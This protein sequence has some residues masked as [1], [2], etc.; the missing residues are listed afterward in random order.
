M[1]FVDGIYAFFYEALHGEPA[2]PFPKAR[3]LLDGH[4][5]W[6]CGFFGSQLASLEWRTLPAGTKRVLH[7]DMWNRP[8]EMTVFQTRRRGLRV[9]TTW[10]V[11]K[12]GHLEEQR[13][14]ILD[15]KAELRALI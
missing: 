5:Y 15:L 13:H 14:R 2:W 11:T 1:K 6:W 9:E 7:V 4:K 3:F 8:V 12:A 10:T